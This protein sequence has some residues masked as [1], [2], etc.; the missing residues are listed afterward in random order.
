MRP[1]MIA[2]TLLGDRLDAVLRA[3]NWPAERV[4]LPERLREDLVHEVVG[5][6]LDHLDFF[7]DDLL[8]AL[9]V[10]LVKG[11]SQDDVRQDV[12]GDGTCSS[13][14]LT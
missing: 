2:Q 12:D 7:E 1:E 13:R 14:T 10:D 11:G 3:E 4:P 8:F 6:V 9:D 5:R